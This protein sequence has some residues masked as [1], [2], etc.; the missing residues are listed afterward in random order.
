MCL[1]SIVFWHLNQAGEK[2][3]KHHTWIL[4]TIGA[5]FQLKKLYTN[6]TRASSHS[7]SSLCCSRAIASHSATA[8]AAIASVEY[9]FF[10]VFVV[11]DGFAF[12]RL[13]PKSQASKRRLKRSSTTSLDPLHTHRVCNSK[14]ENVIWFHV[15][16]ALLFPWKKRC[17]V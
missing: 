1:R 2:R 15:W 9:L 17:C 6:Y 4:P 14:H 5:F 10:C 7:P 8:A 11:I 13:H 12:L 3:E 16:R